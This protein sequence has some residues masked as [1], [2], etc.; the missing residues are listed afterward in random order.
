MK[1]TTISGKLFLLTATILSTLFFYSCKK[2]QTV[3]ENFETKLEQKNTSLPSV[4]NGRLVFESHDDYYHFIDLIDNGDFSK[5]KNYENN[6]NFSSLYSVFQSGTKDEILPQYLQ[7]YEDFGLPQSLR[8]VLNKDGE[9]VI[10]NEIIWYSK[11]QKYFVENL[12]EKK[13]SDVK[14]NPNGDIV[15]HIQVGNKVIPLKVNSSTPNQSVYLGLTGSIANWQFQFWQYASPAG[16]RKYVHGLEVFTDVYWNGLVYI[17]NSK[18]FL[19]IKMEWKGKNWK[20][21]TYETKDIICNISYTNNFSAPGYFS[22]LIPQNNILN[23]S[24]TQSGDVQRL[25]GNVQG[26][27]TFGGNNGWTA[28]VNGTI[29]QHVVGDVQSNEWYNTANPLW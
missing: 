7:E 3:T 21:A 5:I 19:N 12:D 27:G 23:F 9:V 26:S 2:D 29:Y 22:Y 17:W 28:G 10:G 8:K 1:Q 18:L 14:N 4:A 15:K 20:P 13:L 16:W 6:S 24:V 25:I 11:S